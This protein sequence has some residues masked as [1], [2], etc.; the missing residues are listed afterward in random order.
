MIIIFQEADS[1]TRNINYPA[2]RDGH[3]FPVNHCI[4]LHRTCVSPSNDIEAG[5]INY[6]P[7]FIPMVN[8][9]H[10]NIFTGTPHLAQV[11]VIKSGQGD[12]GDF[13][14]NWAANDS[15]FVISNEGADWYHDD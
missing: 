5:Q 15:G 7:K 3:A 6:F 1:C 2:V 4:S 14:T 9:N 10:K 8:F 12:F 13:A 11:F